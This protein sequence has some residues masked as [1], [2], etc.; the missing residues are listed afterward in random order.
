MVRIDSNSLD[1]DPGRGAHKSCSSLRHSDIREPIL[2]PAYRCAHA[3]YLLTLMVRR[4]EAPSRNMKPRSRL[5]PSFET[6]ASRSPQDEVRECG[7][8]V[9][10]GQISNRFGPR[11]R[12]P[13]PQIAAKR[14]ARRS[15]F[16]EP[17]QGDLGRPD[18]PREIIRFSFSENDVLFTPS[19]LMKRGVRVVTIRGVREAVDAT[20]SRARGIAGQPWL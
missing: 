18:L 13:V 10:D 14:V 8:R 19:R 5:R 16:H 9:P 4:R 6:T 11:P 15:E 1:H 7:C 3:G 17:I 20:A 12:F 2:I